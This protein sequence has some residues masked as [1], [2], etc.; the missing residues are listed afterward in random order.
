MEFL[1][2]LPPQM[3]DP[4]LF[5]VPFFLLLLILEWTAAR[6]LEHAGRTAA[7]TGAYH[8]PRR[9]G[10]HLDGAGVDGHH[11]CVEVPGAARLRR[12]LR[13]S[14]AMAPVGDAVVHVGDR[15]RRRRPAVLPVSPD[16]APGP[17][18]LGD[19]PG[20]PLQRVLQLR[21]RAAAEVEQQRRDPDVDSVAAVG[22]SAVDGVLQLLDQPDLPVLGAHRAHRQALAARSSSSSTRRRTTGCTTA[23][24]AST[25]TR[26]TAASSSSGTGCSAPS[27]PRCSG[28]TTA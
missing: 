7:G 4:V 13:L 27:S 15:D 26:T 21:D 3:R 23:W 28:R 5:A 22:C 11:G 24:T 10:E 14:R 20:A 2:F 18:D 17:A 25:W 12:D 19:T 8:A 9:V 1:D 16:R 6:K